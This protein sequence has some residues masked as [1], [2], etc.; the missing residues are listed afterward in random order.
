M[1]AIIVLGTWGGIKI[2]ERYPNK[3]SLGTVC[4]SMFSVGIAMVFAV[5]QAKKMSKD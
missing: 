4:L 3:Y 2:D 5:R 1:I